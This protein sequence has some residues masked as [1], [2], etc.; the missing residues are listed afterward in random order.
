MG[1]NAHGVPRITQDCV[2]LP[3]TLGDFRGKQKAPPE[4]VLKEGETGGSDLKSRPTVPGYAP[5]AQETRFPK[6]SRGSHLS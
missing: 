2:S 4:D 3:L 6:C 1:K 5:P